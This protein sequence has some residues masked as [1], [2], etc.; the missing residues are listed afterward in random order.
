[1]AVMARWC[2]PR[3]GAMRCG[4]A[5]KVRYVTVRCVLL[6]LVA[7]WQPRFVEVWFAEARWVVLRS[8][9]VWQL[10]CGI[11]WQGFARLAPVSY[12]SHGQVRFDQLWCC[13][14]RQV[15]AVMVRSVKL[16]RVGFRFVRQPSIKGR[17]KYVSI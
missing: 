15:M 4:K 17:S 6:R 9:V 14:F 3:L 7:V 13:W 16:R 11:V 1:M 12:G 8:G 10:W 5:V 2:K